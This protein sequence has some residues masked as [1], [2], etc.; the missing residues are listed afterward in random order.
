M[1]WRGEKTPKKRGGLCRLLRDNA[2]QEKGRA[3]E[4]KGI[5]G[6]CVRDRRPESSGT[7]SL[8]V[9]P[10]PN[11]HVLSPETQETPSHKSGTQAYSGSSLTRGQVAWRH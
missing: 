7:P 5:L 8:L 1:P 10:A 2:G 6:I 11:L 9:M 3:W 4:R